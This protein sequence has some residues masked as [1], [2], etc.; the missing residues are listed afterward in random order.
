MIGIFLDIQKAY[1][2]V[3]PVKLFEI[4]VR[5]G[6][7]E[8]WVNLLGDIYGGNT[9]VLKMGNIESDTFRVMKGLRQGCPMSCLLFLLYIEDVARGVYDCG[10][11]FTLQA[12]GEILRVPL[13]LFADDM[14]LLGRSEVELQRMLNV[15]GEITT[16]RGMLFNEKKKAQFSFLPG[17]RETF[18]LLS[19]ERF[20]RFK[21]STSI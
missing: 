16:E 8:E 9:I 21:I 10:E 2:S 18:H 14:V 19:R 17:Q 11:G 13:L 5:K 7:N 15:C 20:Y 1:D 12:D 3:S 6:M 4:L